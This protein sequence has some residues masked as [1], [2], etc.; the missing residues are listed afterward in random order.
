MLKQTIV[1]L[2][3]AAL[4]MGVP[5]TPDVQATT[6]EKTLP[7]ASTVVGCAG[8]SSGFESRNGEYYAYYEMDGD[9]CAEVDDPD[10]AECEPSCSATGGIIGTFS[11][12]S[13][14]YEDQSCESW[15]C[16]EVGMPEITDETSVDEV[17]AA[18]DGSK[19]RLRFN[20]KR[21]S[22]QVYNC[23]GSISANVGLPAELAKS[24][25]QQLSQQ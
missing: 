12:V 11:E 23:T 14:W 1:G 9:G 17:V 2:A 18:I 7:L 22:L 4:L 3:I 13:A 20:E 6:L 16:T 15:M 21:S 25:A 5:S 10:C 19:G 8:C 24:L